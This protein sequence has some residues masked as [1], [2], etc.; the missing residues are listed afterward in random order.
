MQLVEL[1]AGKLREVA[2]RSRKCWKVQL[3]SRKWAVGLIIFNNENTRRLQLYYSLLNYM[4]SLQLL[5]FLLNC[6]FGSMQIFREN[7]WEV[8]I[9][10]S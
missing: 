8:A 1:Y 9:I 5:S 4:W 6:N 2:F 10:T 7:M 3:F